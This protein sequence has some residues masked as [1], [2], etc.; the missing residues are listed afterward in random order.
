MV[1]VCVSTSVFDPDVFPNSFN[2]ASP[3]DELGKVE[4]F[5]GLSKLTAAAQPVDPKSEGL[6]SSSK[7]NPTSAASSA[8]TGVV[9]TPNRGFIIK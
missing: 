6:S 4:R 3:P 1:D 8:C 7:A 5:S 9:H 2:E